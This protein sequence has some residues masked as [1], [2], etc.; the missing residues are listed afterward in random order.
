MHFAKEILQ[1]DDSSTNPRTQNAWGAG[2]SARR[3]AIRGHKREG[4][5]AAALPLWPHC[6]HIPRDFSIPLRVGVAPPI[7]ALTAGK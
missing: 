3:A 6:G 7:V 5:V 2:A 4:S 1:C